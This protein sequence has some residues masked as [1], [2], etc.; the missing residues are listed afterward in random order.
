MGESKMKTKKSLFIFGILTLAAMCLG[1]IFNFAPAKT[2]QAAVTT[3]TLNSAEDFAVEKRNGYTF[4]TGLS[5]RGKGK[6]QDVTQIYVDIPSSL[7]VQIIGAGAFTNYHSKLYKFTM[8][9]TVL[10][11]AADT[12]TDSYVSSLYLGSNFRLFGFCETYSNSNAV[13]VDP[14]AAVRTK[15]PLTISVD[16]TNPNYEIVSSNFLVAKQ[17]VT[18]FLKNYAVV[19]RQG[20]IVTATKLSTSGKITFPSASVKGVATNAFAN[21]TFGDVV[22]PANITTV[23]SGAFTGCTFRTIEIKS[24]TLSTSTG[25]VQLN[26]FK[27]C[28]C[29]MVILSEGV[30]SLLIDGSFNFELM[31][32]PNI[33]MYN[34]FSSR[35]SAYKNLFSFPQK[36]EIY[37]SII[38]SSSSLKSS[39]YFPHGAKS[40]KD[41]Y[42][43]GSWQHSNS[44]Y[45]IDSKFP[46]K[47]EIT[48]D[49]VFAFQADQNNGP[50][51]HYNTVYSKENLIKLLQNTVGQNGTLV[52]CPYHDFTKINV[53]VDKTTF[54]YNGS[55]QAP[56]LTSLGTLGTPSAAQSFY[57]VETPTSISAGQY[58]LNV[59]GKGSY[60]GQ[61]T[62]TYNIDKASIDM[63]NVKWD[64]TT[65]FTYTGSYHNVSVINLPE[66][67]SA[68][69][70]NTSGVDVGSYTAEVTITL[71]NSTNY[72][73]INDHLQR[74]LTWRIDKA[75]INLDSYSWDYTNSLT[76]NGTT[77][78]VRIKESAPYATSFVYTDNSGDSVGSHNATATLSYNSNN[79]IVSG[80]ISSL[81][82]EITAAT[83]N[84]DGLTWNYDPDS[85]FTYQKGVTR[86]VVLAGLGSFV[87]VTY[88]N[89]FK[90]DAGE[91]NATATINTDPD[92]NYTLSG[93]QTQF[94][95]TWKILPKT[96]DL[97]DVAWNYTK[98]YT[99]NKSL[100][101]VVL[102]NMP[103]DI[104]V[105]YSNNSK[106]NAGTYRAVATLLY[107]RN[108]YTLINNDCP[109]QLNWTINKATIDMSNVRWNYIGPTFPSNHFK[110]L[111][112]PDEITATYKYEI[113]ENS[114]K[115]VATVTL[116]YDQENY[117]LV[118]LQLGDPVEGTTNVYKLNYELLVDDE[119]KPSYTLIIII[120]VGVLL[121]LVIIIAIAVSVKKRRHKE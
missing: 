88:T 66:D 32:F 64:Y 4:L 98:P 58:T 21:C 50:Y 95:L 121:L 36:V 103:E 22:L 67:V 56:T 9:N 78:T 97:K 63:T 100:K 74:S 37:S 46:S 114:N 16:S 94:S 38:Q 91:Y 105:S 53:S 80:K 18:N 60:A 17:T 85:P 45:A 111:W 13:T 12:L 69:Y 14:A 107:N 61:K 106:T 24:K 20:D 82:W 77:Q 28:T 5:D 81:S 79:Y 40:L 70:K 55:Q 39:I 75:T 31:M 42:I 33:E 51:S 19:Y 102:L 8:P 57:Y 43:N 86:N 68:T 90:E 30:N 62:I 26:G 104:E 25:R 89:N 48:Y 76:Y 83:V 49:Y 120:C 52:L 99:Y 54:T 34:D 41:Y 27:S 6:V 119:G 15:V 110:L 7:G 73:L 96:L 117:E 93:S 2:S 92:G 3:M 47:S 23:A 71:R 108:N 44:D 1:L 112:L 29:N 87:N 72:Q 109:K 101:T 35:M 115:A 116:E 118:N 113:I 10:A 84:T 65:P 11:M 59:Y